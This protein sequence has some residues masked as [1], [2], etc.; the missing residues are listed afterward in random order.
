MIIEQEMG[1]W[2]AKPIPWP[3]ISAGDNSATILDGDRQVMAQYIRW[4]DWE[5]NEMKCAYRIV[6][7]GDDYSPIY[8][9]DSD[10]PDVGSGVEFVAEMLRRAP[11]TPEDAV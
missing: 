10:L 4:Y 6:Y 1:L 2:K 11:E 8:V 7:L 9:R 3:Q 5:N